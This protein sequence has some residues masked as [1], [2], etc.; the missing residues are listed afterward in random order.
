MMTTMDL[1][2][3]QWGNVTEWL[4]LM[5]GTC[6]PVLYKAIRR[7]RLERAQSWPAMV[8][9][10]STATTAEIQRILEDNP[11][12]AELVARAWEAATL[13]AAEASR[14]LLARVAAEAIK[15]P[16]DN[17][18]IDE[19]S[20]I[21]RTLAALEPPNLQ[22]LVIIGTPRPG[23]GQFANTCLEG[24]L[25]PADLAERWPDA[26]DFI[27]PLAALLVRE[28][29]IENRAADTYAGG[30]AWGLSAFGRRLLGFLAEDPMWN[31]DQ[32]VAHIALRLQERGPTTPPDLVVRNLGPAIAGGIRFTLPTRQDGGSLL[33]NET[34]PEPFEL[35]AEEERDF[36]LWPFTVGDHPPYAVTVRWRDGRGDQESAQK[37]NHPLPNA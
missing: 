16:N 2:G 13:A 35:L 33:Y 22:L 12:V 34:N 17:P 5:S 24:Y 18:R 14:Q 36:A 27:L 3:V 32:G 6:G 9:K 1:E 25:T 31:H 15:N 37:L 26:G 23:T 11:V 28:G 10:L 4:A 30:T 20:F 8:E 19:L 7:G 21:E 29:L